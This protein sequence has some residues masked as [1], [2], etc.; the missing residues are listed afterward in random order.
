MSPLRPF[1]KC[2]DSLPDSDEYFHYLRR[3]PW[4]C[5]LSGGVEILP[6]LAFKKTRSKKKKV[7]ADKYFTKLYNLQHQRCP[8]FAV[9]R[10]ARGAPKT[11]IFYSKY[12]A[13]MSRMTSC[14]GALRV[15][16]H[17]H[18][19]TPSPG[20]RSWQALH[21]KRVGKKK[22]DALPLLLLLLLLLSRRI[23]VSQKFSSADAH[24]SGGTVYAALTH[25]HHF[26]LMLSV[27]CHKEENGRLRSY[28]GGF[29]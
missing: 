28:H 2:P 18:L 5:V 29:G 25:G 20:P 4:T 3:F 7:W 15:C 6:S 12:G 23:T 21:R 1:K 22:R 13:G 16:N 11:L 9:V 27:L 26:S 24:N 10:G 19:T 8:C 14:V 17:I